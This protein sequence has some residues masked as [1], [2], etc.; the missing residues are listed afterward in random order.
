MPHTAIPLSRRI[1]G[2]VSVRSRPTKVCHWTSQLRAKKLI[3]A[4]SSVV[5]PQ[6]SRNQR[7]AYNECA[8]EVELLS[9]LVFPMLCCAIE[10]FPSLYIAMSTILLKKGLDCGPPC[11]MFRRSTEQSR[12]FSL[13]LSLF[14][15]Q[16]HCQ[17]T[18]LS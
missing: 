17:T 7:T 5:S 13:S 18:G 9:E 3:T 8:C 12:R 14:A 1:C 11:S 10:V 16:E 6:V 4:P 15:S 2:G